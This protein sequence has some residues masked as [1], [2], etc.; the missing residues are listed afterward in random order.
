MASKK[1]K[2]EPV[3]EPERRIV[4]GDT[5]LA[6]HYKVSTKTVQ[7]WRGVGLPCIDRGNGFDYDLDETDPWVD[8][9]R[10]ESTPDEEVGSLNRQLKAAKLRAEIAEANRLEREEEEARGNILPRDEYELFA[11]EQI[12]EARDQL[13]RIPKLMKPHLCKKCHTKIQELE[14][15]IKTALERL[16]RL[17]QGPSKD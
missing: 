15:Q 6:R 16:A 10:A 12:Q 8:A 3:P 1:Q 5:A 2:P 7:N 4:S 11:T 13:L 17:P 14:K 9:Y